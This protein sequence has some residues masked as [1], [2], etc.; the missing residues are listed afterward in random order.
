[1]PRPAPPL[2]VLLAACHP[3]GEDTAAPVRFTVVALPDTQV[4][5]DDHPE[6]FDQQAQWV[7]DNARELAFVVHLGDVVD[8]GPNERQWANAR[9]SLDILDASGVPYGIAMGNHDNQYSDGE[10]QY[11]PEVDDSCSSDLSDIDC[12]AEHFLQH[13]GPELTQD[14]DWFGGSSPSGLSNWSSFEAGGQQWLFLQLEV[15][16]RGDERA[17]AQQVLDD[18]PQA[19]VHVSTH[20]YLFDYRVVE[21]LMPAILELILPGR[22]DAAVSQ[23]A[24]PL[25][26]DDSVTADEL[27]E[28]LV[29]TNPNIYMVQ[30]GHVDAEYR[31]VSEN[32]AGL[33]VHELLTDFQSFHDMGGNGWLKLLHYD[34]DAGT[35]DVETYSPYLDEYRQNGDGLDASL[36]I[37]QTAVDRLGPYLEGFGLDPDELQ[38]LVDYWSTTEE[39]RQEY[40]EAAYGD[41]SRDS[42]FTLELD[43]DAYPGAGS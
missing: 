24:D 1:M 40:Y 14:Q 23:L 18:H 10:Y 37:L 16:P 11:G 33:D 26:Y 39:G 21:D 22:Y 35:I 15:D 9:A 4:Y 12:H 25:I 20:R 38:E 19:L 6:I 30:C 28:S 36:E 27:F 42:E 31:Q 3:A 29:A 13:A 32:E 34:L 7:A 5:A 2:L 8:N 41:G 43:F 17:W